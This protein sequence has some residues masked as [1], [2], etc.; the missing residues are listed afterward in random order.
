MRFRVSLVRVKVRVKDRVRV[1]GSAGDELK[2]VQPVLDEAHHAIWSDLRSRFKVARRLLEQPA[3]RAR[4]RHGGEQL[5]AGA[6]TRRELAQQLGL[7]L[8]LG[9]GL[10]LGLS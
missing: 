4:G 6:T 10:R 8:G 2:V 7:G 5:G 1:I 3:P 9:F